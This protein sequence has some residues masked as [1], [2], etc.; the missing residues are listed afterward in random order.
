MAQLCQ[1]LLFIHTFLS[2]DIDECDEGTHNCPRS[3][4][5]KNTYGSYE[6]ECA[7]G[8][9]DC[10]GIW[11]VTDMLYHVYVFKKVVVYMKVK[12]MLSMDSTTEEVMNAESVPAL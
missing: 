6:C 3:T 5:C 11:C 7:D 1:W 12:L 2:I 4:T 10:R 9:G 8:N